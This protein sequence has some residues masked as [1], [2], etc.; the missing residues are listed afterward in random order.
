MEPPTHDPG[1]T[2][3]FKMKGTKLSVHDMLQKKNYQSTLYANLYCKN[4]A[5]FE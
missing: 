2:F 1:L 4:F 3:L 5:R